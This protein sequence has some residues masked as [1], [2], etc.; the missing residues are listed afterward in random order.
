MN[1]SGNPGGLTTI[2]IF[3]PVYQDW[4]MLTHLVAKKQFGFGLAAVAVPIT[5]I[6]NDLM[7]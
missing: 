7:T 2:E 4:T 3:D 1:F 5:M 6:P